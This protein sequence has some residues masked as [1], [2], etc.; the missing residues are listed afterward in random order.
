L[1]VALSLLANPLAADIG[2][3]ELDYTVGSFLAGRK[4]AISAAGNLI[5]QVPTLSPEALAA[6]KDGVTMNRITYVWLAAIVLAGMLIDSLSAQN[7]VGQNASAQNSTTQV[8]N[9]PDVSLG[10]YA[11]ALKKTKKE[12]ATKQFDND[13]LPRQDTLSVVGSDSGASSSTNMPDQQG[14]PADSK[15]ADPTK[16]GMPTTTAGQSQEQREQVY[17]QWK[18]KLSSQQSEINSLAHELDLQQREYKLRAAE[19]Y[20]DA[21]AR[22]R[23]KEAWDKED[24]DYKQQ[25]ADK[26][27]ALDEAKQKLTDMQEDARKAGVPSSVRENDQPEQ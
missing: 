17:D 25:M 15:S 7:A 27:K 11:R 18:Q 13:N 12:Q 16:A 20:G 21:G 6:H 1:E 9:P 22:L 14:T 2:A 26:Q 8:A 5:K 3:A 10:S 24:A 23:N 19:M 4:A